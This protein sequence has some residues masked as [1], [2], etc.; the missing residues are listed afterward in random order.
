MN[1]R[2]KKPVGAFAHQQTKQT[3]KTKQYN[4][5]YY[6]FNRSDV[7]AEN[8]ERFLLLLQFE[9]D[10]TYYCAWFSKLGVKMGDVSLYGT[11][12]FAQ[13]FTL[14]IYIYDIENPNKKIDW[15]KPASVI[16]DF[17]NQSETIL[18]IELVK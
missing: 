4:Y 13:E 8:E 14:N 6:K 1:I 15:K 16:E 11:F 7:I 17:L 9:D 18:N 5:N 2:P 12:S 10:D 3:Q